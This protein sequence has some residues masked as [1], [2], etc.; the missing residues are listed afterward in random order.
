M[1]RVSNGVANGGK[2]YNQEV[3]AIKIPNEMRESGNV[4][5]EV[6]AE[7]I[8]YLHRD[9]ILILENAIDPSH[10]DDLEAMLGPEA[11]LIADDPDHHFNFGKETR[12]MDQ[13]PPLIPELMYKVRSD[14]PPA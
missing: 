8:T 13:A 10:L 12:N 6:V 9:G 1:T 7:A 5:D 4:T 2:L 11:Q 3:H 14:S